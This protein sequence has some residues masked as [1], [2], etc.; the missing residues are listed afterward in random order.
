MEFIQ[1]SGPGTRLEQLNKAA[2]QEA[3]SVIAAVAY[4]TDIQTLIASCWKHQKPLTLFAR[5]DYSGPV[6]DE[7]LQWFLSKAAQSANYQ[8]LMVPDIFHPKV[9]WWRGVG[10]YIGSANL[11]KSAWAGN[12]EAGIFL[13]EEDL[14]D[15]DMR[16]DLEAFF[17]QV[18]SLAHPLTAEVAKEMADS[19]AGG[20]GAAQAKAENQFEKTRRIPR[21]YSLVSITK[22]PARA[23]N[24]AAFLKEWAATLQY[25]RDIGH[26]VSL[27][28]NRPVWV[29]AD[30]S[31]GVLADQFLHAFCY[32]QVRDGQNYPYRDLFKANSGNR[33]TALLKAIDWWRALPA[34]PSNEDIHIR[35]WAPAV[36]TM[37]S[38]ENLKGLNETSFQDL[39]LR[40]H[41]VRDHAKRVR[42][43][44]LGLQQGMHH[45][46]QDDRIRVFAK[47]L[48]GQR[49]ED[50]S[51]CCAVIDFVLHGGSKAELPDRIFHAC[52]EEPKKIAHMGVSALGEMAGWAMPDDFPPRNGRTS[53]ALTALG[54]PVTI[55]SE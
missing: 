16:P 54:F 27:P 20:F 49:S 32:N 13:S 42:S 43:T 47:W 12:V 46:V 45:M 19:G 9:I 28:E 18:Q 50:N 41:A 34:A 1:N 8:M 25:L 5:Y 3:E 29:P 6:S 2:V 17:A 38:S 7:A 39:C 23:K 52:F 35:E 30:A 11:T 24:R 33:E 48:H 40:V 26:R 51:T 55:H 36:R 10:A 37:L 44:T 14:D 21:Q 4:V 31:P 53:K 15:N 22:H